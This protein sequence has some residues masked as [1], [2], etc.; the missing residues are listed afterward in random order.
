V[1]QRAITGLVI[2]ILIGIV[3]VLAWQSGLFANVLTY[4]G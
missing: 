4:L 2:V 3:G 1:R